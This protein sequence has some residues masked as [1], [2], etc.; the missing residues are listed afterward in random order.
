MLLDDLLDAAEERRC[1]LRLTRRYGVF[2]AELGP[3]RGIGGNLNSALQG[4][5]RQLDMV[6]GRPRS[7][8]RSARLRLVRGGGLRGV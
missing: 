8:R 6:A 5:A 3:L 4:L 1:E 2:S 7:P